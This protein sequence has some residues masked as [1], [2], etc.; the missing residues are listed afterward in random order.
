MK[1]CYQRRKGSF[2]ERGTGIP[3]GFLTVS[4]LL[5]ARRLM[6]CFSPSRPAAFG[7]PESARGQTAAGRHMRTLLLRVV[8]AF[9]EPSADARR[10]GDARRF[11]MIKENS[12]EPLKQQR[13]EAFERRE[14]Q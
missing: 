10:S 4:G 2:E 3:A 14:R 12:P 9:R 5:N 13:L 1:T 7:Q 8:C 11:Q 6:N